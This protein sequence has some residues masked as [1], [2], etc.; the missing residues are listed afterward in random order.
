MADKSFGVKE[1]NVLG[2]SG[3]ASI[4]SPTNININSSVVGIS[5]GLTVGGISTFSGNVNGTSF[6]SNDTTGDGTDVG[7]AIKYNITANGSSDYRFAG[8]GVLNTTNDPTLYLQRGFTYIFNNTTG[9]H[10]FRIQFTGTTTGVGTYVSASQTGEQV[11]TI[12]H[13]APA[14]YEYQCTAHASMKGTLNIPT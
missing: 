7:F 2:S 8:P 1:V 13:D 10:P 6:R 11:F 4:T 9:A 3:T 12:P 5:T 14:S